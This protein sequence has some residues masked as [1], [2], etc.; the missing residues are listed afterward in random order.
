MAEAKI[1]FSNVCKNFVDL[2]ALDNISLE[3]PSGSIFGI[4]GQSG[5]GKSTL[6]RTLN[7]LED[8][9]SG[10]IY[11]DGVDILKLN[12][13]DLRDYRKK[14]AMIFQSFALLET[15][16]V[17]ENI[18][19][20]LKCN[21]YTKLKIKERVEE[22]S[23]I[24][25]LEDKLKNRPRELSGGQKQRVAIA[26][27]LA[28]NPDMILCDEATSAL[29]PITTQS[30]LDLLKKINKEL[31]ITVVIVTHQ[32]EVVKAVCDEIAILK[33]GKLIEKGKTA[34]IFL[35]SNSALKTLVTEEEIIPETGVNIKL[36]FSEAGAEQTLITNMAIDLNVNFSI[37]WGKLE[38]FKDDVLGSLIINVKEKD[39]N[40]VI[41][42]LN[43]RKVSF[44]VIRKE[45]D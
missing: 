21:G 30:I 27:A 22:L 17:F 2:K 34:E 7:R 20:P 4:V 32:M 12:G 31:N 38:K 43:E 8:I 37:V 18:A 42:F 39:L 11:V 3:I 10:D 44:E 15:K 13:K 1:V 26:R 23:K 9:D 28:L 24:V 14:V 35:S 19:L 29:D 45:I 25:G 16:N 6:L 5:A 40:N 36:Y 33:N 41:D